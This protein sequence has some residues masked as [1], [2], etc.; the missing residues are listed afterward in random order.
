MAWNRSE[1]TNQRATRRG[2][3]SVPFVLFVAFVPFALVCGVVLWWVTNSRGETVAPK[4][5]ALRS[6]ATL[7]EVISAPAS[8][9][10][11]PVTTN[12]LAETARREG[13][14]TDVTGSNM[15]KE[16]DESAAEPRIVIVN[17]GSHRPPDRYAALSLNCD[18][19]IAGLLYAVP[20]QVMIGSVN[21]DEDFE[22][23]FKD[24]LKTTLTPS[25]D[26]T[27]EEREMIEA[28]NSAKTAIV[29]AM[30]KEGKTAGEILSETRQ[31]M[32]EF[33][34]YKKMLE[35]EIRRFED[36]A[37]KTDEDVSDL[38]DAANRMLKDNGIEPFNPNDLT[39]EVVRQYK[40]DQLEKEQQEKVE[41]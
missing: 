41:K 39:R 11:A 13:L 2:G 32:R 19:Q 18:K 6:G 27:D 8:R 35:E 21:F 16:K 24:S 12:A 4:P 33:G 29:E 17:D 25:E 37:E 28:V 7:A 22:R 5:K 20:G 34:H 26:A 30:K 23:Q 36:N 40:F 14:T 15:V 10:A 3:R 31:Q 1:P 9:T 38:F